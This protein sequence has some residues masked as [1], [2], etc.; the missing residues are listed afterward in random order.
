MLV[1]N[2]TVIKPQISGKE[3]KINQ[4]IK[5]KLEND[6][7]NIYVK[8]RMFRQCMYLL[9]KIPASKVEDYEE[10][11]S[12]DEA[13]EKL[14]RTMER[15]HNIISPEEEFMGHSSNLQVWAESGY[16]TRILHR[17]IAFPLLKRLTEVGD[18]TAKQV[19]KEEI[20]LR[21]SSGHPTVI[22]YLIQNGY[23]KYLNVEEFESILDIINPNLI[24]DVSNRLKN[25]ID[26]M[27]NGDL[28]PQINYLIKDILKNF[29][30]EHIILIVSK[31]LEQ[32]PIASK[33]PLVRA[34]YQL[35]KKQ[36][37][38]PLIQFINQNL[39]YF[40]D[41]EFEFNFIKYKGK[42]VGIFRDEKIYLRNQNIVDIADIDG[43]KGKLERVKEL[44]LS[45]NLI[46]NLKGIAKFPNLKLLKLNNNRIKNL[47]GMTNIKNLKGLYL[48]NNLL[49]DLSGIK[50]LLN[51]KYLDLSGNSDIL[52]IP[53]FF[54]NF[55]SLIKLKLWNCNIKKFTESTSKFFWMDQNYRYYTGYS[56]KD[57]NI[58][59]RTHSK[60]ASQNN[61]LYKHFL[62][63]L[64]K[65]RILMSEKGFTHN[66]IENFY[67]DTL[68]NAIWSGKTTVLFRK[69]L[70]NKPQKKITEY[71]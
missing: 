16:D 4:Y 2:S 46:T 32:I 71:L 31:I 41:F 6:R 62:Q 13:A 8:N 12:I 3:F 25:S 53:E 5:L 26:F 37:K 64:F 17:N 48:R 7:T 45:N 34:I 69:W 50:K 60:P 21:L 61:A 57:K 52:E 33:T 24:E 14:D 35:F 23:L 55:S 49:S 63:W 44:D 28:N 59:E 40:K 67:R 43:L 1:I 47:D 42:I 68:Q 39:Q 22:N 66:D 18:P 51:L 30:L 58:Y 70:F 56:Q 19:F 36:K 10:I 65:M 11:D 38:F 20:A 29:G 54:N 9:L 27:Q 15:N